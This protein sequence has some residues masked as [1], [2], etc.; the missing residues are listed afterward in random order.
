MGLL[1][2]TPT[3]AKETYA[4]WVNYT[5][6]VMSLTI[7]VIIGIVGTMA[8]RWTYKNRY[9]PGGG[10][11]TFRRY[12]LKNP[13]V[14]VGILVAV[15]V[16]TVNLIVPNPFSS[17]SLHD[18]GEVAKLRKMPE[19]AEEA[20]RRLAD[21]YPGI[22]K[23]HFE[24]LAAHYQREDWAMGS[25]EADAMIDPR[26]EDPKRYY[27]RLADK[28]HPRLQDIAK[29]GLGIASY[30]TKQTKFAFAQLA[31]I[32]D[33]EMP[34]RHLFMGRVHL[35][36]GELDSAEYH[37]RQEIALG[38]AI[39]PSVESI[40]WMMYYQQPDSFDKMQRLIAD[41]E[42]HSYVPQTL[43][44]YLYTKRSELFPYLKVI[45]GDW[46]VN[47]QW[48][49]LLGALM[50]TILWMLF[51]R[52]LD[53]NRQEPWLLMIGTF[54]GG[55]IFSFLALVLYDFMDFELGFS[56][57]GNSFFHDF[58]YCVFGIG[59]IE[60]LV[61]IIPFLLLL[62]FSRRIDKPINYMLYA[63]ASAMGFAFVENLMYF[64]ESHVGIM[65]GRI[66]LC[67]V[68][69]MFATSTIAFAMM[70]GKFKYRK[71][72]IPLFLL[73]YLLASFFH[74]F[75]DFWL[76]SESVGP[77]VFF[78]YAFFIYATFQ[79][80]AY[81]NNALNHT[82]VS[83]G[84]I[85][86]DPPK[87]ALFLTVGLIG[88]LL[89]EY[90]G[91]SLVYGPSLGN[92]ALLNS[93]GMGSFLMFFVVM[94][95]TNID[96]VQGEWIWLR[97]WDFGSRVHH[98]RALGKRLQLIPKTKDSLLAAS[99]PVEGEV[100]SR[101][102]LN[103]DNRYFLFKFDQILVIQGINMEYVLL[104]AK[105]DGEIPESKQGIEAMVIAFKDQEAL[106]RK[107]KRKADFKHIDN[108]LIS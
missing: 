29:L 93:L 88:I 45:V 108:V 57:D 12:A 4:E 36:W 51:L 14:R 75:Y 86:L 72:Q 99:L 63:S 44:R 34:Y 32:K 25:G 13:L 27:L 81:L 6:A 35:G 79:Y 91:L 52:R 77:L 9:V 48:I 64:D 67:V 56:L 22:P 76:L 8:L 18:I 89:F 104:R 5:Q 82:H 100:I 46:W 11:A 73:G 1:A 68:F 21:E 96:V 103:G 87:L 23:Y 10:K 83:Q 105:K 65:H 61:K 24:Y 37:F 62:Q 31:Q 80:A 41:P 16:M 98:N 55:A 54:T 38:E 49:G 70:L 85:V 92:Y 78:T 60:E 59:A 74:G 17:K 107:A 84:Q 95:L 97:L 15:I 90:F 101:I 58:A 40:A 71:L 69:H 94:N 43:K 47:I 26:I 42:L 106:L 66:L 39:G 19:M 3:F 28:S 50:G 53:P 2:A 102:S 7:L 20:Y 33:Q 30:Y